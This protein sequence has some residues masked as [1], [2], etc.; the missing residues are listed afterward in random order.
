MLKK[1][2]SKEEEE[3]VYNLIK[4]GESSFVEFKEKI[5]DDFDN[6][7]KEIVA[8]LNLKG[9]KILIGVDD[10]RKIVD[11]DKKHLKI[12]KE[13]IINICRDVVK[14]E[15]IPI[16]KSVMLNGKFIFYFGS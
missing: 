2:T 4:N 11:V 10:E 16:C 6:L 15:I 14:P 9:G 5:S 8:F 7:S 12:I 1:E 3:E 13:K